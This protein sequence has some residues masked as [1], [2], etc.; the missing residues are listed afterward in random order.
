MDT[1][2]IILLDAARNF[3]QKKLPL[4]KQILASNCQVEKHTTVKAAN[5]FI[6]ESRLDST[7]G[8]CELLT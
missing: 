3:H 4:A 1:N 7:Q 2:I 8:V 5:H 6:I